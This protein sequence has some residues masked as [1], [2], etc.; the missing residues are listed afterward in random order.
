M[1]W[2]VAVIL[3]LATA[4][5]AA[6]QSTYV[7]ASLVGDIARFNKIDYDD[8][9]FSRI[10]GNEFS[11]DGEALGFNVKLGRALS[12]RWGVELE[13]ARTGVFETDSRSILP[14]ILTERLDVDLRAVTSAFEYQSQRT[15]TMLAV[16]G[17]VR[18]DLGS[19]FEL[20]YL[21]GVSFNRVETEQDYSGPRILIYPPI[22]VPD[23]ETTAYG[24]GPTVG[25]EAA[26]KFGAAAVTGGVRL[27]SAIGDGPSG[28]L[29]RPNVGLRW[30]F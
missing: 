9:V 22:A 24:T 10:V 7:G 3:W 5:P 11:A 12:E 1:R 30:T 19:R 4:L 23:Y 25:I 8:D 20:S 2:T 29:I 27:Q 16:L 17:W 28:W 6:A 14:T 26:V 18:Q 15:H 13:F 21:G